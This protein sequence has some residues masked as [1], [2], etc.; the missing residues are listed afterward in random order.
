MRAL[1]DHRKGR[2]RML[3]DR[4]SAL[5]P[6]SGASIVRSRLFIKYVTLFVAVVGLALAANG[7]F[8]VY[9]SYQEQTSALVRIQR[10]QAESAAGKIGQFISE[11]ESQVGWTT[12]L[13]WSSGT[14]EQRR[15][16]ALRLL[17]QV[18]AITELA[19]ID[20]SGHE[21]LRVSRL[22]M[23]VVGSGND[24][25]K[26]PS[27][28]EAVAHKVYF[29]PVYF[30]RESEPYMTLSLA[31]TRRDT[32]V[33][34]AQVNLKLI[35]DV[36]SKI[37]FT[38][39]GRAYVV[40]AAGRLIAHPDISLVLRNTDMSKLAQVRAARAAAA[41]SDSEQVR[42]AEDIE[43]HKVLTASAPVAPLGWH[44]FVET[45][46]NEAYAPLYASIERTGLILLGALALAFAAGMFLVRRMVVPIQALRSGAARIGSGDLSQRIA[47]KTGDEI[48]SLADQF[49]DMAGRLQESYADLEQKVEQ[50][51]HE[52]SESLAQ[53]TATADV[54]KVISRSTFDLKKVL[55]TLVES[56]ARLCA[57]DKAALFQRDGE[58]Y[59]LATTYG[60]SGDTAQ[61]DDRP[62]QPDRS[63]VTGRVALEGKAVHVHD[64][65][66]DPEYHAPEYQ[67]AF[68]YRTNLGVPL[69][70][71]GTTIGVFALVRDEVDPFTEKQIELVTTFADQAVIA[72]ENARLFEAEQQR[73]GELTES[74]ER[75]TATSEVLG[76][77]SRSKFE[78]LPILQSVADTA[79]RLCRADAAAIF[80]LE[81]GVYRFAAGYSL[82][83]T[84]L[85]IERQNRIVP[86]PETVVGR[87]AMSR[88]VARI[89][90][91]WIDPLYE[92]K[93][94]AKIG[95]VRSMIG[96]PLMR[97]GEPIG[98]IGLARHRVEPFSEREIELVTTFADQAVIAIEN[99][100][101]FE[102]EQQRTRELTES[103]EQQT[104]TSEVLQV[105][106]A[107]PGDLEPVFATTL[108]NAVRIC[109]AKFGNLW[110]RDG[111]F[112]RIG[113]THGA[114]A[115]WADFLQRERAFRA[116]PRIGL[117]Q[118]LATKQTYQVSDV[119]AAPTYGDKLREATIKLSG[120][121]S[122]IGVP[123][124]RDDEAIGCIAI[125][126]QEVQ[127]F[128]DKQIEVVQNFAAQ[129][130]IA[131]EN[132]RLLSELRESLEQQT[133][134]S[135]V[136]KVI[137]SSPGDLEPVFA[138][139]LENAVRICDAKFGNIYRWEGGVGSLV[140]A[141]NTPAAFADARRRSPF[142]GGTAGI[143]GR[144]VSAKTAIHIADLTTDQA[145]IE[146]SNPATVAA[147]ELGGVRTI[148][149]VPMLKENELVGSFTLYRQEVR[150]FT[151]K[152][153]AL[154]TSFAA[155]AVI[156]IENA[157][158]LSELRQRTDELGRSV[159]EL[160]ALGEV[161]QAVNSTL[162]LETVLST[163]VAKAVQLSNTDAGTIYVFDE[164]EQEFHLRATYGMDQELIDALSNR[165]IGL[166]ETAIGPALAQR[167]PTQVADLREVAANEINAIT[168]RAGFRARLTAPLFRGGD[169]VGML[170]VRR[171]TPGA[172]PQSTIDLI[173]TFAA[174]SVLAIQ[175]ARL[176]HEI[177][178]KSHELEVAG[179]HKSQFLANMSHELRTPLNAIIGYSEILQ[180][181]VADLGQDNVGRD[182]KKI[183]GAGR[184]LLGLI[185]DILD[186]SKVEA[187]KMDVFLED[188][189][190]VP[191]LEE[192]RALIV[193]LAE[194]NGNTLKLRPAKN[195]GSMHTDR[196][197]LKQSLLNI[198]SNGSK[199]TQNGRLTL[200]AE[201]FKAD[202]PMVRFAVSD[203]GIG[204]TE[205][206]LGRLFQAF[207]QADAS[208]TKKYGGTGLGL[209][210]SRR[211]CQLLGGDIAVTSR[212]G[213]G[214]TFT[215]TLP[216]HS[217]APAPVK[218]A[219]APR[220]S[221]D[222]S[223]GATVLI[224]DDDA[225]ARELLSASLKSAGYRLV[226]AASGEEALALAR[227][228]RPD[229]ITLDVM[230]PKPDGWEVLSTLKADA[231]LCDIPVVMVTMA[232]DRGIGLSLGAVDV[233]TKPVDRARLTALIHRL[234]RRDGPV[235]VVED[236]ADTREMMRHTIEKLSLSVAEAD[237]GRR[238][239][240]WL[241]EHPVPAMILLDLMMPEMDGFEFL[242]AI[243]ARAEWRE[244]PVVVVTAKP[245][246]TAE[247]DRL[248]RQARKVMEKGTASGVDIAAA[249]GEAVRRRS[250]RA[251]AGEK[252]GLE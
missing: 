241:G 208:T 174:Q 173:K 123:L 140:A 157:R 100:R 201:R 216:A 136:L 236:D 120:A 198:L 14:L 17:R 160:R 231:D 57:A 71:D 78:L 211:F 55:A 141:H 77:I 121:R 147:V 244:I 86:G 80:R 227:T 44:V 213:K 206:Q 246:T 97:D 18:P 138:T 225:A 76:V 203:T 74:L 122:L 89:D 62:L 83:P 102:A 126:R 9:F 214:S 170:V 33:S 52:L 224:V 248:L 25:S 233:L 116:D 163:I 54:L 212:P 153:I 15:F 240:S 177:E 106:S 145:Y 38:G 148:M 242:D 81:S 165:H 58:V 207:S 187:G 68:G 69:L 129:A 115:A 200:V 154:V 5:A 32:G 188:V 117:G 4:L 82:D 189:E 237:N 151:D 21:Q 144:M 42:E 88:Q 39:H 234:V 41:G 219:A 20:S 250:A 98:V 92:K 64:V 13:P 84:Y 185:N 156:A 229:A 150:P 112:F 217:E 162:D 103:L 72:I 152:Q 222:A 104:A 146:R 226:H 184:H 31:G 127:P 132:A 210:I 105:I 155:Q 209:A 238:A 164:V 73:T 1:P 171:R 30:R 114:P 107:S 90:D 49:N 10:E 45:P 172:F 125:Y 34:I 99:V 65:L 215:I 61:Y 118:V 19:E 95:A 143:I 190:I 7:A 130:V 79:A 96:V 75:Q 142:G 67:Q 70:R 169:V 245:L 63:S 230:M 128:T 193:P 204:M 2:V 3:L 50:R 94:D 179:Q 191:L 223:N 93:D 134:T 137:S 23:E 232:P 251:N 48:E 56:A 8:D 51:T 47:I 124:L 22:A 26:D 202:R 24:V 182:L 110:L 186:L 133:A 192:V 167:E 12:Q 168:L 252:L 180:E 113:A 218:P 85:E 247:R 175:N 29:G 249:I 40:D 108:E 91:A 16:D 205:Q 119:T 197:K 135:E 60:F 43:G 161:S 28:A 158:L 6:A 228:V 11:I 166:D 131:I 178:D 181:D 36:L 111:E 101:L 87:A 27:F 37:K 239:L 220:I 196:T 195:L 59:R 221:P 194:K 199:F 139:M 149:A 46:V 176:F 243:A 183:E 159:G 35:W 66:A 53:Q 235:L 109:G